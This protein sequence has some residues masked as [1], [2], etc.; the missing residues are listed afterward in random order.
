MSQPTLC[1]H[2]GWRGEA[3]PP[4]RTPRRR[5]RPAAPGGEPARRRSPASRRRRRAQPR[6]RRARRRRCGPCRAASLLAGNSCPAHAGGRGVTR[7]GRSAS[8]AADRLDAPLDGVNRRPPPHRSAPGR[9]LRPAAARPDTAPSRPSGAAAARTGA[10]EAV[11]VA[12]EHWRIPGTL[13]PTQRGAGALR[14]S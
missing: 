11:P 1:V 4:L 12:C 6:R 13:Q 2:K 7:Q 3:P 5:S 10:S 14:L 8:G 9:V